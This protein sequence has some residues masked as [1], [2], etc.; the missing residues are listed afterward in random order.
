ML[1]VS[2]K[3]A[4]CHT[5]NEFYISC[6][7]FVLLFKFFN[8]LKNNIKLK[9]EVLIIFNK[10]QNFITMIHIEPDRC[11]IIKYSGLLDSTSN[12]CYCPYIWAAKLIRVVFHLDI[13]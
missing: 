4:Y 5:G 1:Y 13:S 3:N 7:A 11:Q 10:Q 8:N 6:F 2:I 9:H 12:F